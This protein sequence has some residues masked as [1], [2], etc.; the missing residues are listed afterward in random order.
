[1][2]PLHLRPRLQIR[3][4]KHRIRRH[5]LLPQNPRNHLRA[6]QKIHRH[7]LDSTA[8]LRRQQT[9]HLGRWRSAA[10]GPD[11]LPSLGALEE[12]AEGEEAGDAVGAGYYGVEALDFRGE[13]GEVFENVVRLKGEE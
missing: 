4:K 9:H 13:G 6:L 10:Q 5:A 8:L 11:F 2:R 1:M 7:V 12:D 3:V